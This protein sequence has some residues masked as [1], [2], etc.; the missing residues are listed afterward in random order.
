[1][2]TSPMS[3]VIQH[4]RSA[5]ERDGAGMSDGELLNLFR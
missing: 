3:M 5:F 4:L 1:M 2:V